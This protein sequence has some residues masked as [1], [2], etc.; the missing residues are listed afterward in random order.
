M[1]VY[2]LGILVFLLSTFKNILHNKGIKSLA[3][4]FPANTFHVVWLTS[5]YYICNSLLTYIFKTYVGSLLLS[6]MISSHLPNLQ[7]Y[8][9]FTK[10]LSVFRYFSFLFLKLTLWYS[11][12]E[13][14][15]EV[16]EKMK[17]R[18]AMW[19]SNS[20]PGYLSKENE[21]TNSKRYMQSNI[22]CSIIYNSQDMKATEWI[23]RWMDK[24]DVCV[25]IRVYIYIYRERE[26]EREKTSVSGILLS[27]MTT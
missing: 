25:Y 16:P 15:V 6:F 20:T 2:A 27:H 8:W 19:L 17:N 10:V 22:Y 14:T 5:G 1:S 3:I 12:C 24:E 18:T 4:T 26:R 11:H 9:P 23:N 13:N 7:N 21:N